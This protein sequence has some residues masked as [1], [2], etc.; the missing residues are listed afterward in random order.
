MRCGKSKTV[1]YE[2]G[3]SAEITRYKELTDSYLHKH[4]RHHQTHTPRKV[5]EQRE[6]V[7][8]VLTT[9]MVPSVADGPTL[10]SRLGGGGG[11]KT[12]GV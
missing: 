4:G 10:S 3:H 12:E 5:R 7:Y 1:I 8:E 11:K 6:R 9:S 2:R